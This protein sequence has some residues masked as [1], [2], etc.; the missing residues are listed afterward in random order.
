MTQIGINLDGSYLNGSLATLDQALARAVDLGYDAAE[1]SGYGANVVINGHL[2]KERVKLVCEITK[3]Y[4]LNYTV[5]GP[6]ELNLCLDDEEDTAERAMLA[7]LEFSGEIG[8]TAYV[9]HSGL[10][11]LSEPYLG[12]SDLPSDDALRDRE[13]RE[14][15]ALQRLAPR[16]AELGVTI[17]MENRDPHVYEVGTL[18]R[19]GLPIDQLPRYHQGLL[20]PNVIAQIEQV[21][22]PAVAMTLDF[23]HTY[24]AAQICDFDFLEAVSLAAP[25]VKHIHMHDNVGKLDGFSPSQG[26]RLPLGQ[27]D[28]HLPPGWGA[29]PLQAAMERLASYS[30]VVTLEIRPRYHD[31]LAEALQT[32]RRII[33]EAEKATR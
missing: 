12:I 17:G 18:R 5:H 30:S 15:V 20:V 26:E 9:Y 21:G 16:A 19:F 33:Q 24:I 7:Y 25:Y 22:H 3:R 31:H 10:I 23:G 28:L 14:V 32:A 4:P 11:N 27:G 13:Q 6:C 1:I 29:I 8:A 2:H